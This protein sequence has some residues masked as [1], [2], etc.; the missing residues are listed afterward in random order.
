MLLLLAGF[1]AAGL[2]AANTSKAAPELRGLS[3]WVNSKP[4][5]IESQRGKVV[6]LQ[7]WTLGCINCKNTLPYV[8]ELNRKYAGKGLVVLGIHAPEF[9]YE[10]EEKNLRAAIKEYGL[11]YPIAADK[12]MQTWRA[13][14]NRYWPAFYLIDKS[15]QIV[16]S[17]FGEGQYVELE[18]KIKAY[19]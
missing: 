11:T 10:A 12:D 18:E 2:N 15:G 6:L 4:L 3:S 8:K 9:S 19:L 17:Q 5:T 1:G 14:N 16:H 7:F 13:Y